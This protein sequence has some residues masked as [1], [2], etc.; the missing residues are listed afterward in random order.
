M[1]FPHLRAV[2][3]SYRICPTGVSCSIWAL[4]R[5]IFRDSVISRG[6]VVFIRLPQVSQESRDIKC[7]PRQPSHRSINPRLPT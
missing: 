2:A 5:Q 7:P 3:P 1:R 4:I 6:P